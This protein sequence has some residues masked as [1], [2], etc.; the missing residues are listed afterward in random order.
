MHLVM[1]KQ[2]QKSVLDSKNLGILVAN[3]TCFQESK[4]VFSTGYWAGVK[5]QRSQ[6]SF[7]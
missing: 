1:Q 7:L 3:T 5:N 2:M 6:S 4:S